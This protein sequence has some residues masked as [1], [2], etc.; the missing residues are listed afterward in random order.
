MDTIA[1]DRQVAAAG[2][3]RFG[4]GFL[5]RREAMVG[6]IAIAPWF[7]GFLAFELGPCLRPSTSA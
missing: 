4:M 2:N 6:Y 1:A 5:A 7:I 3:R